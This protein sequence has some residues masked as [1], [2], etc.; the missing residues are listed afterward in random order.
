M[1]YS[2]GSLI[3]IGSGIK[4]LS[5]L[6]TE[7]IACIKQSKKV[8][9]SV[10]EP[11]MQNWIEKNNPNAESLNFLENQFTFRSDLYRAITDYIVKNVKKPQDVCVVYYGHPTFFAKSALEAVQA[12]RQEGYFTKILPGISAEDCLFADL[13]ID[14]GSCGA[15]SYEATDLLIHQKIIDASCHVILW[16]AGLIGAIKNIKLHNNQPGII[17]LY[18]YLK[19]YY[20]DEHLIFSYEAALYPHTQPL[21][22]KFLLKQ[23]IEVELSSLSTIYIPPALKK[24]IDMLV[25][26]RLGITLKDVRG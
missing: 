16:Q 17:L 6:T 20:S 4:T 9:Y 1:N 11:V 22:N 24:N 13:Y 15:H 26:E 3:I 7:A 19:K 12:I 21:I 18:E 5:H 25:L 23:L 10:N 2:N 14:P 8:I